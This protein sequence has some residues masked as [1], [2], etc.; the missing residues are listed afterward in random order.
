MNPNLNVGSYILAPWDE[1]AKEVADGSF[2]QWD[3][4]NSERQLHSEI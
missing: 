2:D 1:T 4:G 3:A